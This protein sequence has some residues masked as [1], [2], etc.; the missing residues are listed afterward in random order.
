M[1]RQEVRRRWADRTG[2]FSPEYYAHYGADGTS[3]A[4]AELVE[5]TVGTDASVLEVGCSSGRH[6]AHLHDRGF[7][8]LAG[9]ELNPDAVEVMHERFPALAD[10]AAVHVASIEDCVTGFADDRFDAVFS[11]ET[12]QHLH[13]DADWVY[14]EIARVAGDLVVTAENEGRRPWEDAPDAASV[15]VD[16]DV[17]L[18][19]RDWSD[20][21]T[22]VGLD[23]VAVGTGGR[24]TVRAF[25]SGSA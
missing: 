22:A 21:F 23:Q 17:P 8:D 12:L 18:F 14:E 13:P 15:H 6:L 10:D 1:E 2:E 7:D 25:R 5:S 16:D 3:E 20:V 24:V 19:Y 4:I 11:V 9:V